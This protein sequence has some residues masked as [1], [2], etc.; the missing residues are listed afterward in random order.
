MKS[1]SRWQL[2]DF[3][4]ADFIS[5]AF[6]GGVWRSFSIDGDDV[7]GPENAPLSETI[8]FPAAVKPFKLLVQAARAVH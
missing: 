5:K 8:R 3:G 1:Y 4:A 7:H 6:R 2:R